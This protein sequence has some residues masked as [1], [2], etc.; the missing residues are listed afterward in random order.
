MTLDSRI[1]MMGQPVN[2]LNTLGRGIQMG[3]QR[4]A[5]ALA[6]GDAQ[7]KRKAQAAQMLARGVLNSPD[8]ARAYQLALGQA[9]RMG[10]DVSAFP[11]EYGPGAEVLLKMA[12]ASP[13]ERSEFERL[14]RGLPPEEAKRALM[15]K[16]GM[17]PRASV[18]RPPVG[19]AET[20]GGLA[21][22]PGGPADPAYK[23]SIRAPAGDD[24][25]LLRH[26]RAVAAGLV[27]GSDAYKKYV[28]HG[29]ADPT[30][31]GV[32]LGPGG[33]LTVSPGR[34]PKGAIET[35]LVADTDLLGRMDEIGAAAGIGPDGRMTPEGR[36]MLTYP[37]RVEAGF[38]A[39]VEKLG[40]PLEE[41]D[42]AML[43]RH[44][45]FTMQTNQLFN[46]YRKEITGAAAAVQ[47]LE[48]LQKAFV[49]P[50][51]SPSE[52]ESAYGTYMKEL[53]R[54]MRLRR[55]FL[56]EG[57]DVSED[58]GAGGAAMDRAWVT[59]GDDDPDT[60]F[61]ELIG[62]GHSKDKAFK[63]MATEGY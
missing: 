17:E 31:P 57:I 8:K 25:A 55:K 51:M 27:P 10:M 21:P 59:G 58:G 32:R 18:E 40:V 36:Y 53:K 35:G 7:V 14:T 22:I 16:L 28:L 63:I 48:R 39:F 12:A 1:P 52:F 41:A 13:E 5:N 15:I 26:R 42:E 19:F 60:R 4:Q 33:R 44:T 56:R 54:S 38:N 49:N 6:I 45:A 11:G 62:A 46:V 2:V 34:R 43:K 47:E 23:E 9:K 50:N 30:A 20:P 24:K 29:G 61:K 3:Q 37:G